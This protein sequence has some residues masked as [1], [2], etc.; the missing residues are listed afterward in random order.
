MSNQPIKVLIFTRTP[1]AEELIE[2]LRSISPRFSIEQ[3]TA[4]TVEAIDRSVWLEVEVLYTSWSIPPADWLPSLKWIQGH[5]AGVDHFLDQPLPRSAI[6]TTMSGVHAPNM[7]EYILM[8]MLAFAYRLPKLIEYQ[9]R[10]DWPKGRASLFIP[11][12][13][14]SATLGIVGYG[15]IGRETARLAKAF[16]MRVLATKRDVSQ[17]NEQGWQLPDIGDPTMQYVDRLYPIDQLRSLLSECDFVAITVPL[18]A[19]TRKLIGAAEFRSMKREAVIINVARGGVI[20]EA[21]MVE[22]LQNNII[23]GAGL[24]VFEQ[25]PLPKESPLWTLPNVI[26]SP[27]TAGF[28]SHYDERA[29]TL[30]AENLRR[31][32]NGDSLLNVVD[33]SKGY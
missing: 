33:M 21:A 6:L 30:F 16:R 3:R 17:V 23:G 4:S 31:Y 13:L 9:H 2:R 15:S 27:H 18:T 14:N 32:L 19:E 26:I 5:F 20:D 22:A 29:M 25:E 10:S 11:N 8:M 24:D 28:S 7:A 12:E 1:I